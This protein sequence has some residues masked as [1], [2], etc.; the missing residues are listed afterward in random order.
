MMVR[1]A[2]KVASATIKTTKVC[3]EGCSLVQSRN[4]ELL[5]EEQHI[6]RRTAS[7]A[8]QDMKRVVLRDGEWDIQRCAAFSKGKQEKS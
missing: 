7:N 6:I 4:T 8:Q 3:N 5:L 1:N 2:V